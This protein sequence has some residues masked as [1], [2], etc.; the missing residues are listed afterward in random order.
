[1]RIAIV[2]DL[3][4]SVE[5]MRR[6]IATRPRHQLVWVARDG[7]EAVRLCASDTPDL[8]LMDLLM[9]VMDGVEATRRIMADS[10]CAILIV[11]SDPDG[12]Y[13]K[14][15]EA[16]GAG[17]LDVVDTPMHGPDRFRD[18]AEALMAKIDVIGKLLGERPGT[19]LIGRGAVP[20]LDVTQRKYLIAIGCSAG[21]PTALGRVLSCLPASLPA[22]VVVIQHVDAHFAPG[23]ADWLASQTALPVRL[24]APDG[25]SPQ[26]GTVLLAGRDDHLVFRGPA[27]LAY[28]AEP[29]EHPYRPSVDLFFES[30]AEHWEGGVVG[31][32]LTGMGRDGARGLKRLRDEG[33]FT[34]A[35]DEAS[36]AVYGMPK[37]AA[38]LDAAVEILP[39]EKIGPRLKNMFVRKPFCC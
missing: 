36:S 13:S 12:Q 21:G 10:P 20:F 33:H 39:L 6:V 34:M 16:M 5:V 23:L 17:A 8:V 2:N 30:V 32:M 35:Q 14:V 18:G 28:T 38:S 22:A 15:F 24:A 29:R 9:P 19:E 3:T 27:K 11:T 26:G 31:V 25:D 7:A 4:M 1:M 37:A